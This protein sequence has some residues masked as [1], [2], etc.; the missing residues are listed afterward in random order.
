[1]KEPRLW[2]EKPPTLGPKAQKIG[3]VL[4]SKRPKS[5]IDHKKVPTSL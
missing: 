3:I 2:A 5:L 1:M 4:N